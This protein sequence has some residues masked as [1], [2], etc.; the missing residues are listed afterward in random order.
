[1]R[2][3][4]DANGL[5]TFISRD[6]TC[7]FNKIDMENFVDLNTLSEREHHLAEEMHKRNVLQKIQKD[8]KVGY[9]TFPQKHKL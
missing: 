9:K 2:A 8:H 3:I 6:E 4:K 7:L 5:T 1:M